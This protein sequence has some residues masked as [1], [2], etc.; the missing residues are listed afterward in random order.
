[1]HKKNLTIISLVILIVIAVVVIVFNLSEK[2]LKNEI[3]KNEIKGTDITWTGP[4]QTSDE[5]GLYKQNTNNGATY[6]FRGEPSN[7][8]LRFADLD[9]RI[10]RINEDGSIRI[11]LMSDTEGGSKQFDENNNFYYTDSTIKNAVDS[12]YKNHIKDGNENNVLTNGEFC[13]AARVVYDNNYK[14]MNADVETKDKYKPT[15]DCIQ[16]KNGKGSVKASAGL[17]TYDEVIFAG[18]W[19]SVA[20]LFF[21]SVAS[22]TSYPYYLNNSNNLY[23]WTM[24][25]AGKST[26]YTVGW[27]LN[28]GYNIISDTAS[29]FRKDFKPVINLKGN[30]K[31]TGTGTKQDPYVIK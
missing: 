1:M 7:N 18:G 17:M 15:F 30:V 13:E 21:D 16:D 23:Y 22:E 20:D 5:S 8:Y 2:T 10:I 24:S 19:Y 25:P 14:V 9:W 27:Y 6:Y 4:W 12:W 26:N 11:I 29:E 3:L 28:E 31:F